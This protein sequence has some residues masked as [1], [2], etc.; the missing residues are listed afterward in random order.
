MVSRHF[1]RIELGFAGIPVDRHEILHICERNA[2]QLRK[3]ALLG[4]QEPVFGH[5]PKLALQ[6][7]DGCNNLGNCKEP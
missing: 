2:R 3:D 4:D 7:V 6:I 5:A 1:R